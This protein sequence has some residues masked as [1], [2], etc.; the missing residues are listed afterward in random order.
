MNEG[1]FMNEGQEKFLSF[2]LANAKEDQ[3][4]EAKRLLMNSFAEQQQK[5]MTSA[6]F[7]ELNE[8]LLPLIKPEN[9]ET[10][11]QAMMHFSQQLS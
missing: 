6:E 9:L 2:F 10:V 3:K 11:T 7:A 1:I 8:Q 4:E 5:K